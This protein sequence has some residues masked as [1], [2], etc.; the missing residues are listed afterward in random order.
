M[1]HLALRSRPV[2]RIAV[3]LVAWGIALSLANTARASPGVSGE[4]WRSRRMEIGGHVVHLEL[5]D[6]DTQDTLP[7]GGL[8][9]NLRYRI[10]RRWG[11]ETHGAVLGAVERVGG[12]D[13]GHVSR[14]CM[15]LT[16]SGMFYF[17]PDSRFQLYLMAGLGVALH[18]IHYDEL[19]EQL[20]YVTP[21]GHVGLGAQY[22]FDRLRLDLS[23]RSLAW[24]RWR[25]GI[26]RTQGP[27]WTHDDGR[28]GY[29]PNDGDREIAGGML[30]VGVTF[31]LF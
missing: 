15:P 3:M 29:Q 11:V 31:G 20:S 27:E 2:S 17:F 23:L 19:G 18:G 4:G 21:V 16:L 30:T 13:D 8:G 24:S 7:M 28:S 12:A 26:H 9:L 6:T 1:N 10:S 22:R 5:E 14:I 25:S